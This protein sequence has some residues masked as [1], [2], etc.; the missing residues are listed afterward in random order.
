VS[1]KV[2]VNDREVQ[3]RL[4]ALARVI[5]PRSVLNIANQVMQGSIDETFAQEGFPAGS[6]R[7]VHASTIQRSFERSNRGKSQFGKRGRQSAAFTRFARGKRLLTDTGRLRRSI[8]GRVQGSRL[9]IG[10][11]LIYAGIHQ[12]GGVIV[13]KKGKALRFSVGGGK[14]IFAKR[15]VIPARPFL[16]IKPSDPPAIVEAVEGAAGDGS[17]GGL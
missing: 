15:V 11:N 8:I 2:T 9:V 12:E 17:R 3:L 1:L 7:R 4:G 13:P 16:L 5:A 6:W 10:T 14:S